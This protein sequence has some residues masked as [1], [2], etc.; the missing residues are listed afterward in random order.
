MSADPGS[1]NESAVFKL[2]EKSETNKIDGRKL[3]EKSCE[4]KKKHYEN[5][6]NNPKL[7]RLENLK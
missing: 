7:N 3:L 2:V 4:N 6:K 5:K 1:W